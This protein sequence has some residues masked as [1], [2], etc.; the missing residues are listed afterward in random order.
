VATP[1]H[2]TQT[3]RFGE[4]E[5]DAR[6]GELCRAGIPIKLREQCFRI[7]L[8]LLEHSG[9]VVARDDLRKALWPADT[10]VDFDHSLNAA[11]MKLREALGDTADKPL[12]IETIPKRG[13]RF[14]V[15]VVSALEPQVEAGVGVAEGTENQIGQRHAAPPSAGEQQ[16]KRRK[17]LL[18]KLTMAAAVS[19]CVLVV[20]AG[21]Y[22]YLR[23][24]LL[25]PRITDY[26][27]I[28]NDGINKDI[29]GTDGSRLFVSFSQS[30]AIG[31]MAVSGG[32]VSLVPIDL[33]NREGAVVLNLVDVSPDGSQLLVRGVW[34]ELERMSQIWVVGSEG[35]QARLVSSAADAAWSP[36]G[37]S[38]VLMSREGDI[39]IS[40]A[41][42]QETKRIFKSSGRFGIHPGHIRWSPDGKTIRFTSG[43]TTVDTIWEIAADGSNLHRLLPEWNASMPYCCGR[44]TPD[45]AFYV[46]LAGK[47]LSE[48]YWY[49]SRTAQIWILDERSEGLRRPLAH[50]IQLT[51]GPMRWGEPVPSRDGQKI[52]ARGA[53]MRG[54]LI[55][56]NG[57]SKLWQVHLGGI[58][59]E[60]IEFSPD[61]KYVAY[62]SYPERIL[63]R[64]NRDGSGRI[65]LTDRPLTPMLP[66]WS[67]DG[68]QILFTDSAHVGSAAL[69]LVPSHGGAPRRLMESDE[70]SHEDGT[71]SPDGKEIAFCS[72][73]WRLGHTEKKVEIKILNL[74]SNV[75]TSIPSD[76][77]LYSPRWSPDGRYILAKP[78]D[79]QNLKLFELAKQRWKTL[80]RGG[81]SEWPVWSH[82]S[83]YVYFHRMGA[84]DPEG[85]Y[86]IAVATGQR[87]LVAESVGVRETGIFG[88]WFGLDQDDAPLLLRDAGSNELYAL[89]LER[90]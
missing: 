77:Q 84:G 86:R 24:P 34:D 47:T 8:V 37:K 16:A 80:S 3:L 46:F 74:V 45:G 44:W 10:F 78:I 61:G 89:T 66:H 30:L 15:P 21:G 36:D 69:Y 81:N 65:Q 40:S 59:A 38:I 87:E 55:R 88:Q 33:P 31:R 71:W 29:A 12:Y 67:P 50:P 85:I 75:V 51:P 49:M 2:T 22:R 62:V 72:N 9:Q 79:K 64:A 76:R 41:V 54:E 6:T 14:I 1:A 18:G 63:W 57:S 58:S 43:Y 32:P 73:P 25:P 13:Y 4:F 5:I 7:L 27:Q 28:T 53:T 82:D 52:Y 48:T 56:F 26:V 19:V 83:R 23:R 70:G 20:L 42:S 60:G 68:S 11:V 90:R 39:Y 17:S 35:Y